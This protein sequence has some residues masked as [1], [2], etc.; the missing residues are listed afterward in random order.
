M[1]AKNLFFK[2][3]KKSPHWI[4]L[5]ITL[6]FSSAVF[7]GVGIT[8][9]IPLILNFLGL[10]VLGS[11][12]VPPILAK[13]FSA[14]DAFP[15]QYRLV[16][17]IGSVVL[18]IVLK[19]LA[20]YANTLTSGILSRDFTATLRKEGF[21]LLLDV[22][23]SYFSGV[24]LG[25]LMNYINNEVNRSST[26]V[27]SLL[28]VITASITIFVLLI[29]L[30]LLSWQLTLIATVLLGGTALIS[31]LSLR[32]AKRVGKELSKAA[33]ALSSRAIEVLSGI[34]LV[35][36][37][38]SEDAEYEM[39]ERLIARRQSAEYQSQL[40]QASVGPINEVASIFVILGLIVAGRALFGNQI[41]AFSRVIFT[42]LILLSRMIPFI[43]QLNTAR[44]QLANTSASVEI[45][46]D[47]LDRS[48][49]PIMQSGQR[50]FIGLSREIRFK[51]IWF[52]YPKS[53]KWNLQEIDLLLPKGKMMALVGASGAGKS[54]L[55]DLLARFYDPTKGAVE[56]DGVDLT[57][58]DVN[59]YRR[60]IGI[61]SQDTF[62]FN[63]SI[64]DNIR[65]GRPAASDADVYEAARRA[66]AVEFIKKLPEGF[67]TLIGDRGVLLS[68]GQRQRLGIARALLQDPDILILD[69]ATSALDTVSERLIQQA[70][71]DLSHARTT[72]VIAHRLSTIQ[73]ADKIVVLDKGQ[74][75]EVGTHHQLMVKSGYYANLHSIQFSEERNGGNPH[76]DD[77]D[78]SGEGLRKV[79]YE[80]R[81][82]LNGMLGALD[83]LANNMVEDSKESQEM[84]ERTYQSAL[85]ILQSV[86]SLE[87]QELPV[88][89][90]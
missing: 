58:F 45:I 10:E 89:Q 75:V 39:I 43:G 37:S 74:V 31:Q 53:D 13:I 36:S 47:F 59:H 8:L 18:A 86:E 68:G 81:S 57:E 56:I 76:N 38:A 84:L 30:V 35:K 7:N 27:R 21:R 33:A 29:F 16:A 3:S 71:E 19:N 9:I 32:Y 54:T 48:N 83:C 78:L 85:N 61:V 46:E 66:N 77:N 11:D 4:I 70:L 40:I 6:G 52:R 23:I 67:D 14:F 17:M 72:L 28:R 55:A 63:A 79:S 15:E 12:K 42:Y 73:N 2:L 80:M 5:S 87:N 60:Q 88:T 49:K 62:L 65:Y 22:D 69:E 50:Q 44:N 90:P 1:S 25:D 26:A 51:R 20:N 41:Q 64:C 24:K 82:Q 34:R